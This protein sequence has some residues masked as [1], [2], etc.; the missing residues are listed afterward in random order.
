MRSSLR[1]AAAA[2]ALAGPLAAAFPSRADDPVHVFLACD[3]SFNARKAGGFEQ[4]VHWTA[5]VADGAFT[6]T[7]PDG[8]TLS[9]T[10]RTKRS[11][12]HCTLDTASLDALAAFAVQGTPGLTTAFVKEQRVTMRFGATRATQRLSAKLKLRATSDA[13]TKRS[14][15]R[16]AG[17]A[18]ARRVLVLNDG[19]TPA[20]GSGAQVVAALQKAGH[21]VT[22]GGF[23]Q[24]WDGSGLS[25]QETVLLLQGYEFAD[26]MDETA[27][28]AIAAFVDAG[29]GLV[30]TEQAASIIAGVPY[31]AIDALLPVVSP[32]GE[33][34]DDTAWQ[35]VLR[36]H[37]LA[38]GLPNGFLVPGAG[39]GI[40]FPNDGV[41]VVAENPFAIPM[42][43]TTTVG[44][45]RVVYVNHDLTATKATIQDEILKV[46]VNAVEWTA[47]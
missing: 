29:G 8:P 15:L 12:L 19:L 38:K 2:L 32:N 30:R 36:N 46:L 16:I 23:Y 5:D 24:E 39:Y 7:S 35:V 27:D 45:G 43:A 42:L 18:T 6:L 11:K 26:V 28:A 13:G 25:G 10:Y 3:V 21:I 9:G 1:S 34:S 40:L 31:L 14:T 41:T 44:A 4:V 17:D 47:P 22:E 20:E 33:V 37:P